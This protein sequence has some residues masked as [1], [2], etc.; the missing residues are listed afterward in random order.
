[1]VK[2]E[3][4]YYHIDSYITDN[5]FYKA[6]IEEKK[7]LVD[8]GLKRYL[9]Q[10]INQIDRTKKLPEEKFKDVTVQDL[11]TL[12]SEM[13]PEDKHPQ[14]LSHIVRYILGNAGLLQGRN[15][16]WKRENDEELI[17][18][19]QFEFNEQQQVI[20]IKTHIFPEYSQT[21]RFVYDVYQSDLIL[22]KGKEYKKKK[23]Q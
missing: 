15:I 13:I 21:I 7:S 12:I 16:K 11:V 5:G 2:M 6:S 18:S 8:Y 4:I 10:K 20:A 14:T 22:Q 23:G 17:G 1:M 19:T 9:A 3:D